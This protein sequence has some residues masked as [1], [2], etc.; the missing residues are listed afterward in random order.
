MTKLNQVYTCPKCAEL[1]SAEDNRLFCSNNHSFDLASE[2]YVN[3]LLANQKN[4]LQPGDGKE[5]IQARNTFLK[6]GH[7]DF[8][9]ESIQN[10]EQ[11]KSDNFPNILEIGCGSGFYLNGLANSIN[12]SLA[13]GSD[14]SKEAIK[15]AAKSNKHLNFA[16]INS[17]HLN[18]PNSF[19]D[20]V[21]S[22]F[23][24]FSTTEVERIIKKSG[25]F[26]LVRPGKNHLI[27]LYDAIGMPKKEKTPPPFTELNLLESKEATKTTLIDSENLNLLIKMSPLLWKVDNLNLNL[28]KIT[29]DFLISIYQK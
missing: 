12:P 21:I 26:I 18:F 9:L 5:M 7:F 25:L 22:I 15:F 10:L 23:S 17:Y 24:P 19:F 29:F 13:I 1:L 16:V 2:G 11:I 28:E 6:N 3:L 27:E 14:I 20:L 8:L 4:S